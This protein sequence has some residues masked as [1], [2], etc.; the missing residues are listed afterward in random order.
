MTE[1]KRIQEQE[2]HLRRGGFLTLFAIVASHAV[3]ETARDALFL[4]HVPATRLPFVYLAVAMVA[5]ALTMASSLRSRRRSARRRLLQAQLL[6]AGGTIA[7]GVA[8]M[9]AG[10]GS[11]AIYYALYVWSGVIASVLVVAFWLTLADLFTITQGKRIYASIGTGGAMGALAGFGLATAVSTLV[12]DEQLLTLAALGFG[13]SALGPAFLLRGVPVDPHAATGPTSDE[14]MPGLRECLRSVRGSRYGRHVGGVVILATITVTLGDY[15]FKQEL[16]KLPP[17]HLATWVAGIH[18]GLNALSVA[19]LAFG[20]TPLLRRISLNHA[21][22]L[23]PVAMALTGLGFVLLPGLAT[24]AIL[25]TTD[26]SLRYSLQKT[27]QEILYLPLP[28]DLRA[29]LKTFVELMGQ[30]GAR[31][32]ASLGILAIVAQPWSPVVAAQA[33]GAV[34]IGLAALWAFASWRLRDSYLEMFR[35]T[36]AEGS[37]ETRMEV[38]ELDLASLETLIRALNH[39]DERHVIAALDLLAARSRDDLIPGVILYHPSTAVIRRSLDIFAR[40]DRDDFVAHAPRLLEHP[41][42]DVRAGTVRALSHAHPQREHLEAL[43]R[44]ECPVIRASAVAGLAANGFLPDSESLPRLEQARAE[45]VQHGDVAVRLAIA[46]ALRHHAEPAYQPLMSALLDDEEADVRREVVRAVCAGGDERYTRMLVERLGDRDIRQVLRRALV[47]RGA[48]GLDALAAALLSPDTPAQVLRHVPQSIAGF[49]SHG[50]ARLLLAHLND[51][52]LPGI[53]RFK[54]LRGLGTLAD[55]G[56]PLDEG[57]I[58]TATEQS[59]ERTRKLLRWQEA[60]ERGNEG[61]PERD[62]CARFLLIEMLRDKQRLALQRIFR[63]L[64]LLHPEEDFRR[65]WQGLQSGYRTMRASSA[66]LVENLLPHQHAEKIL[67]LLSDGAPA[68]RL[69]A[70]GTEPYEGSHA[71]LLAELQEDRS[72][73]LRGLATYHAA[74]MHSLEEVAGP[75]ERDTASERLLERALA[76]LERLPEASAPTL[77]PQA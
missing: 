69:A 60:L 7:F 15:L 12:P 37:I 10:P 50:A 42:A 27:A 76:L 36:L 64:F 43:A 17:E 58:Q 65:I 68:D 73:T 71:A 45:A 21:L 75:I 14:E 49:G 62:T 34:L 31:A 77:R 3:L 20:V 25:K 24:V 59:L 53:V 48:R 1:Q 54:I 41:D 70:S 55:T 40:S 61:H 4:T 74:E 56:L 51:E 66:E 46:S 38:P 23:L 57:V 13:L 44:S 32:L 6:A 30:H 28:Q 26:G 47:E 5:G 19:I 52:R 18:T 35:S 2:R 67:G 33:I 11:Q 29:S 22:A 39:P 63:L 16:A 9:L 72:D 8:T